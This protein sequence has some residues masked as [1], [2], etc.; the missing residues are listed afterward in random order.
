MTKWVKT[1]NRAARTV[2]TIMEP[3]KAEKGN[4]LCPI[5]ILHNQNLRLILYHDINMYISPSLLFRSM[6][7]HAKCTDC[8]TVTYEY[9]TY[10]TLYYQLQLE[11][12]AV[13]TSKTP[14]SAH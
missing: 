14:G 5:M 8:V 10:F 12:A 6:V 7:T 9:G 11:V 4:T 1:N 13:K 3:I 2:F